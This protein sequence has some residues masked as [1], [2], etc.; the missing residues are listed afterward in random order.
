[1]T[2]GTPY[3]TSIPV[4]SDGIGFKQLDGTMAQAQPL[5]A[6]QFATYRLPSESVPGLR[7]VRMQVHDRVNVRGE[8]AARIYM[9]GSN[10][11]TWRAYTWGG[12]E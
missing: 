5:T 1:M 4:K 6:G 9:L 8:L 2:D 7:P 11:T 10:R 3:V 12:E